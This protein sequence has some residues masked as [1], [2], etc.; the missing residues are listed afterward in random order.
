MKKKII[1]AAMASMLAG[2]A[3]AQSGVI[4]FGV[5]DTGIEVVNNAPD[6]NGNAASLAHLKSGNLWGSRWGMRGREDLGG[7]LGAIYYLEGGFASDTGAAGQGGR[8]FG[9]SVYVGL[10]GQ[11]NRVT[12]GRQNN[13]L[14]DVMYFHDPLG[15]ATYSILTHDPALAG[16]AD[17]AVKYTGQ[18]KDVMV[19][20]L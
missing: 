13:S 5:I 3:H 17:N 9:R 20:G 11:L 16:R 18:F 8:L 19:T 15:L 7:G 6:A 10:G 1:A 2:G 12:V 4:I 14:Y